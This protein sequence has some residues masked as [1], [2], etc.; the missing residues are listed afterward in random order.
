MPT[1]DSFLLQQITCELISNGVAAIFGPSSKASSDIVA[2]IANTTGIPHIEF[3][4][5]LEA[6][7]QEHLNH[8]MSVNVAPTLTVLSRAYFEIVKTNYEWR[9]F[10]L[11]YETPEGLARLQDLMNIHALN[12]DYVKLRNLADYAEDYRVLWKEAAE[13]FHE[14]RIIM[15]CE[16]QT[17]KE[18]LQISLDFKL[19]GPF[20]NWFLT[21]LD[22]HSSGL[23]D[24]YNEDFKANITS[25][26][27][28]TVDPNPYDRK[29][30][31]ISKIDEILGNQTML[32]LLM[33]DA[34]VLLANS[35]RNVIVAMPQYYA[36]HKYCGLGY[37][38]VSPW[39]P[40]RY[41]VEE[42]KTISEDDVEPRFKTENMRLD[43]FG[44][45]TQF[46][47]E[48]YKPTVNE[49]LLVWTP[50]DGIKPIRVSAELKSPSTAQD[51][52]VQRKVYTVVTH[53][54]EPYFMMKA[55]HENYRGQ[56]K[57]EGYAVDL[58]AKL[59]ELMEF[60]YEF[61][62][63]NG[64]GK[65]NPET[66]Q[67]DG[68]I[69]KLIDH[70]AQIG[71]CDLTITQLRRSYVD[72][73]VP[74]MQLG[75]SILHYKS[76][77]APKDP[78]A[79]LMPFASEVWMYVIFAQL[80]MTL[81][82][83][84][85]ARLSYRE[86]TP[87]NPAI[88]DPDEL[89]NIWNVNNSSWLMVG[90]IMQQGC[91][92]LPRGPHMRILTG[93][94]WFFALMM[95]STYTANLAAFLTSNKWQS[96]IKDLQ[97]LIEQDEVK[98]GSM[99]G[100]STSLF[101]SESNDTD[102][103]RAWNQMKGFKPSAF[104]SNNKEGVARVRKEK[105]K[106]AFLMETTSLSYNVERNCDLHEIGSQIGEKHYGLAVPL[107]ADYRTNLSVSILQLSEKGELYKMKNKWW[108][109]HNVT[110]EA[111]HELD[112]D[113]LSIIELGGVFLVLA[114]GVLIG[115]LI[116]VVEFL[117]NVQHVAVEERVTPWQ[118]LKAEFIFALKFWVRRKPMRISSSGGSGKSS[119]RSSAS[120]RSSKEKSR[121]KTA[122]VLVMIVVKFLMLSALMW[123][124]AAKNNDELW[125]KVG[126]IF[127]GSEFDLAMAFDQAIEE[128]NALNFDIKL[129]AVKHFVSID[130]SMLLQ[131][132][133]CDLIGNG[134]AAI[135]GP[136]S[137]TSSDIVEVLCNISGIPHLQYDW[138]PQQTA[139]ERVNHQLT[140]NVA[141][142][143]LL[144]STALFDILSNKDFD[145]K[146]FTIAY[147]RNS[148][149]ARLQ[150]VLAWKQLHKN[151]LKLQEFQRGDDY[152]IL[153][154]RI[155]NARERYVL[156]DCPSDI[157]TD[158][159]NASVPFNMTGAFNHLFLSDL[160]THISGIDRFYS[161]EF[162][163]AVAAMRLRTY[164]P[165]PVHDETDVFGGDEENKFP[166]LRS[167]LLYDAVVLYYNSL[168]QVVERTAFYTP[169]YGCGRGFW[170]PGPLIVQQMKE[171]PRKQVKPP[172]KTQRLQINEE[173][174]RDD[175]NIEVYNPL[176][177]RVTHV[178]N[179]EY[180]LV[181]FDILRENS[182]QAVKQRLLERKEDFSQKPVRYTVATR[183]GR[184][185]FSW[186]EEPE[187]EHFEGNERFEGYAVDLIYKL[188]EECGFDFVF[189]PVPD[190]K[191]GSYDAATDEWDGIIRQL[192]DNNAQ[193]GICD[194]TITQARRSVVDFTVPFMQLGI[195]ILSYK[196]P[197]PPVDIYAFLN[198]YG[199]DVWVYV[200]VVMMI[201]SMA[202]VLVGRMD[203]NEWEPPVLN[204]Q[205]E[206]ERENI[207]HLRNAVWLVFGSILNQGC[208]ML[209]RAFPMRLLT[210]FWWI[211]ALLISQTYIAKL[212]AFITSSKMTGAITNLHDLVDQNKVQFGTVRGGATSVY[213]SESNDTENRM[214]WN[215][216]LS[217]KPDAFTKNNEEGVDR[218]KLSRGSYAFLMETTNLQYYVQRNC[219]LTQ[220]G[221]S[222]GEKHY[223]IAVP[224]NA[225]FRSNLSVGILKLSEQGV[226][227]NLRN[228]WFNSN[229]SNCDAGDSVVDDGQFD[230]DSVGGLF[231]VL[232]VG[233]VISFLIGIA[234]FLWHVQRIAVKEK[235]PP[236]V[237][238]KAELKFVIRFWLKR[239]PLK[240]YLTS[241]DSTSTGYSSLEQISSTSTAKK[242]KKLKKRDEQRERAC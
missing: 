48:I 144:L 6:T 172:Y 116:G 78:F 235:I 231:V 174:Q 8:Q 1:T 112:G 184:P 130:D 110:C 127:F 104:T 175:F 100:G 141:P 84:F 16:P 131:D 132:M 207:W 37:G 35:A 21:H 75:I 72:F 47:L 156:L 217:V 180:Q 113:E 30:T 92:I 53:F 51:F 25:V 242:R 45:R 119:R 85:I 149:L 204:E 63:V 164:I 7:R 66:R 102:Y 29:K 232:I 213:F 197:P 52:S 163:V 190:N 41:I 210:A 121:S 99:N 43:E 167:Q 27:L 17:L 54:E 186:R 49:P 212:A 196:E 98:F 86:W 219:E 191:Y 189:E 176:I 108:K 188:A 208:D 218:V 122:Q 74:F 97:D 77:P 203:A 148:H 69:R 129:L 239:K 182:T 65:Y 223:G 2:Q 117:W 159:I 76:P 57:F 19:Q 205:Q 146:S 118:A 38:S 229:E 214:A 22:T 79:F 162:T 137:K 10:T 139:R 168:V 193:I 9:T 105:G 46:N 142:T 36:P 120:R 200:M 32:P 23:K 83:V 33:Y 107:G 170:Q 71:V 44:Q 34:V 61:M 185:Y 177:D 143:E 216:M 68:I 39:A 42:M 55:D 151:G 152:R 237:A 241:R 70:H 12:S 145:W 221:E 215:K 233:L 31:R 40:G 155:N 194:L 56:E 95:L 73:T 181:D 195:S 140:V 101:F 26:R 187:G 109:N 209:P 165:P 199:F 198:P 154:K 67:W 59:S 166:S 96:T 128:V 134:V 224:L 173:G 5:K 179:K 103:Q 24:I 13:T 138:H 171:L 11:V 126:A 238:M 123:S 89:E 93:M 106:Y 230:M 125:V 20:R 90:S 18:L 157:L 211:F 160:D 192:I 3:D 114:G 147:E 115:L 60:D 240:T 201:T 64:N 169:Q 4:W 236:M 80:V 14:H 124:A 91:D 202:L 150:H 87:P 220:I 227:Y 135:F 161:R 88:P 28:K 136:S 225:E 228:K 50:D 226:L 133:T 15:D 58:I 222:F 62:I 158:V 81:A 183:V 82:F 234:E 94:W 111:V 153:W 178:W 206:E